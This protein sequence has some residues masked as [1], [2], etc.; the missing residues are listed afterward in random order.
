MNA[1]FPVLIPEQEAT[2]EAVAQCLSAEQGPKSNCWP[3]SVPEVIEIPDDT[4]SAQDELSYRLDAMTLATPE[5][6]EKKRTASQASSEKEARVKRRASFPK[7]RFE[8]GK[9]KVGKRLKFD[10]KFVCLPGG[11]LQ[12][13]GQVLPD[14][15]HEMVPAPPLSELV[16][17]DVVAGES[18]NQPQAAEHDFPDTL[19]CESPP[20][21]DCIE[22]P[23]IDLLDTC[24]ATVD[25]EDPFSE[26]LSEEEAALGTG[27]PVEVLPDHEVPPARAL[28]GHKEDVPDGCPAPQKDRQEE[29]RF[30]SQARAAGVFMAQVACMRGSF[31][32]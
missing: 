4:L 16:V 22:D 21:A 9:V 31:L 27:L 8:G 19:V 25:G 5:P 20:L 17:P 7:V 23:E 26:Q 1:P 28:D 24:P 13:E 12:P 3:Q 11:R 10:P 29:A 14:Q 18:K 30:I 2:R 6:A 32:Q 15:F